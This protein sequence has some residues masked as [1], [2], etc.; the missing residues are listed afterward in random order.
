[1]T[2]LLNILR[3]IEMGVKAK[4]LTSDSEIVWHLYFHGE[5]SAG[6]MFRQS[7]FSSTAFYSTLKRLA[8]SGV[9]SAHVSPSDRRSNIYKLDGNVRN[10]ITS[11]LNEVA[12]LPVMQGQLDDSTIAME[13]LKWEV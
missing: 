1:M 4:L 13:G 10:H 7:K 11:I 8:E 3:R 9:I 2:T 6:A 5:E 12:H